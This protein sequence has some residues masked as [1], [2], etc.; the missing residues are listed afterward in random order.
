MELWKRKRKK[1]SS[2]IECGK[3]QY[4]SVYEVELISNTSQKISYIFRVVLDNSR[5]DVFIHLKR[6]P[7]WRG[8]FHPPLLGRSDRRPQVHRSEE[9]LRTTVT[10]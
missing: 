6:P 9:N 2:R 8:Q 4:S 10:K 3:K 7:R 5:S 1:S